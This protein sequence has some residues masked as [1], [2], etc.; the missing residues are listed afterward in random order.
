MKFLPK[1]GFLPK[2]SFCRNYRLFLPILEAISAEIEG[3]MP[4]HV[5]RQK[6]LLVTETPSFSS[7]SISAEIVV[8]L[9]NVGPLIFKN[10][11]EMCMKSVR[12][13]SVA[14]TVRNV[15][16]MCQICVGNL[17]DSE[18]WQNSVRPDLEKCKKSV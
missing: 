4:K 14:K 6:E 16:E 5:F 2:G 1:K 12:N 9:F 10:L 17:S 8:L 18:M 15:P 3:Y 7:F 11:S 13:L